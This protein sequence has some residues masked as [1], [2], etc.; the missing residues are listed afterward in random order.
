MCGVIGVLGPRPI[1]GDLTAGLFNLQHRGQDAAGLAVYDGRSFHL[2]KDEGM[3]EDVVQAFVE[4]GRAVTGRWGI[5][6]VRYPTV[7]C[8]GAEDAQPFLESNPFGIALA[9]NGNLTNYEPL[10]KELDERDHRYVGSNCDAEV[11]L[12]VLAEEM[13]DRQDEDYAEA[14]FAAVARVFE[15]CRGSY[16]VVAAVAGRGLLAFRDPFGI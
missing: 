9:H 12:H 11:I 16:S 6:H 14:A 4:R 7:G 5:G 8:G 2:H 10:K 15:R 1:L 13:K 3:V